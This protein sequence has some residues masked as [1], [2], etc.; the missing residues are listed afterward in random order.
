LPQGPLSGRLPGTHYSV[1]SP[2]RPL[3]LLGVDS[4][5]I[6]RHQLG[7]GHGREGR[8]VGYRSGP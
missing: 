7:W 4:R 1:K 8:G 5:V 3:L 2:S 6:L